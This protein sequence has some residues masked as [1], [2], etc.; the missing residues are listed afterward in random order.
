MT[1]LKKLKIL[2]LTAVA[3][4]SIDARASYY[5]KNKITISGSTTF[6]R[7]ILDK[8][9]EIEDKTGLN[10]ES[11]NNGSI[12]G[13]NDLVSGKADLAMT[14]VSLEI[15]AKKLKNVDTSKLK[16]FEI[17][18][19]ELGF[20]VNPKNKVDT[21]SIDQIRKIYT[22]EITNWKEVG[23]DDAEILILSRGKNS[24]TETML[25]EALGAKFGAK[26]VKDVLNIRKLIRGIYYIPNAITVYAKDSL[27]R[28]G[29]A[30]K[31]LKVDQALKQK[32]F[33]VTKGEPN[34]AAKKIIDAA[35]EVSKD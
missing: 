9:N 27:W 6:D 19:V 17:K 10:I 1:I 34:E 4:L 14:S 23:G 2:C 28:K 8:E 33:L 12:S 3:L 26:N 16:E 24:G 35:R 7:E 13:I 32:L 30:P 18:Q 29:E 21:L 22:G 20:L 15:L 25:G 31:E 5:N 11:I